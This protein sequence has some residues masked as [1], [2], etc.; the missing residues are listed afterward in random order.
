MYRLQ[1]KGVVGVHHGR[2][3]AEVLDARRTFF[4]N[5]VK[6]ADIELRVHELELRRIEA[7]GSYVRQVELVADLGARLERLGIE[8]SK[9]DQLVLEAVSDSELRLQEIERNIARYEEQ[10][11]TKGRIISVIRR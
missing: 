1:Q 9:I 11:S 6:L 2:A 4:D 10:L 3:D 7:D 8:T 5:R